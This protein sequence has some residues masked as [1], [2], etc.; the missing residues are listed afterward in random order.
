MTRDVAI[1]EHLLRVGVSRYLQRIVNCS[2][3]LVAINYRINNNC[4]T[5]IA[6][7]NS[8]CGRIAIFPICFCI[9]ST[10]SIVELL[11]VLAF[12]RK[13]CYLLNVIPLANNIVNVEGNLVKV[14]FSSA[15]SIAYDAVRAKDPRLLLE[16]YKI[17]CEDIDEIVMPIV[18]FLIKI[19]TFNNKSRMLLGFIKR[20][21]DEYDVPESF[22]RAL[23]RQL[24]E[25][26]HEQQALAAP[27]LPAAVQPAKP[28]NATE[29]DTE[30]L[31]RAIQHVL[32]DKA[33]HR[34]GGFTKAYWYAI[35]RVY[36]LKFQPSISYSAF[37]DL[38]QSWGLTQTDISENIKHTAAKNSLSRP[39]VRWNDMLAQQGTSTAEKKQIQVAQQLLELLK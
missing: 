7:S 4:Y 14:I 5:A 9:E 36:E 6:C 15:Y 19:Y 30:K 38:M 35:Y 23:I 8:C 22:Y 26:A 29:G 31:K 27:A 37:A 13:V 2:T 17:R 18:L 20:L 39:V 25:T 32:N 34:Q 12:G 16:L 28:D 1:N 3:T 10:A 21:E 33:W 24:I 11:V